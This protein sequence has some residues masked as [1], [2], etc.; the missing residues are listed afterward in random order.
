MWGLL[1]ILLWGVSLI[2]FPTSANGFWMPKDAAWLVGSFVLASSVW[3]NAPTRP[4]AHL[5]AVGW[6]LAWVMGSFGWYV[7]WPQMTIP[8]TQVGLRD[9]FIGRWY[10]SPVLPTLTILGSVLA[11]DALLRH[12]DTLARWHRVALHLIRIASV[13]AVLVIAQVIHLDPITALFPLLGGMPD[14][15]MTLLGNATITGNFLAMIAPLCL[16]F[17]AKR[18]RVGAFWLLA[19]AI[20]LTGSVTSC[21]AVIVASCVVWL[22]QRRWKAVMGML[23][24]FGLGLGWIWWHGSLAGFLNPGGRW[25]MWATAL[26]LWKARPLNAWIGYG[27]GSVGAL[28]TN[29]VWNYG[30]LHNEPLQWLFEFGIIGTLLGLLACWQ[31]GRTFRAMTWDGASTAWLGALT[32]TIL[33]SLTSFPFRIGSLCMIGV[34]I[35]AAV[36][37]HANDKGVAHA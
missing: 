7:L 27:A 19:L 20:A 22:L 23:L 1:P 16:M 35:V 13:F 11:V 28:T 21:L 18:Y 8:Q 15:P 37:A 32:A 4:G 33:I 30:Y 6:L 14:R 17:Q 31:V 10:V 24:V 34:V 5:P 25:Q 3:W 36:L 9:A 29:G 12:T 26:D 2:T